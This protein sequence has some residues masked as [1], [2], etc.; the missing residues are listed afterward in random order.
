M[1]F[2][3]RHALYFRVNRGGRDT[4]KAG[5]RVSGNSR[6]RLLARG[7]DVLRG[8]FGRSRWIARV[9]FAAGILASS[10]YSQTKSSEWWYWN[11]TSGMHACVYFVIVGCGCVIP[12]V[13]LVLAGANRSLGSDSSVKGQPAGGA[14]VVTMF[15][16]ILLW[17]TVLYL[18]SPP[19]RRLVLLLLAYQ[20]SML[21]APAAECVRQLLSAHRHHGKNDGLS[22]GALLIALQCIVMYGIN[23]SFLTFTFG[24]GDKLNFDL[25]PY[26]GRLGF[27]A[28]N[29]L[30]QGT[31]VDTAWL[32]RLSSVVMILHKYGP[33][34]LC[35]AFT[36]ALSQLHSHPD[37]VP[38][39]AETVLDPRGQR[40]R[41]VRVPAAPET[42][43]RAREMSLLFADHATGSL[44]L[45][46]LACALGCLAMISFG[47]SDKLLFEQAASTMGVCAS[48]ATL[49]A[50]VRL[51]FEVLVAFPGIAAK[52]PWLMSRVR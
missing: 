6:Q 40:E 38:L 32:S 24:L 20:F 41:R 49:N 9:S 8:I 34:L 44:V 36:A 37:P 25:H 3:I 35:A 45:M 51:C 18:I 2:L 14:D 1:W 48:L 7:R 16:V 42:R 50:V 33:F 26:T 31:R 15:D 29:A 23:Q 13:L 12:V 17:S 47:V 39:H 43:S 46:E 10:I 5:P 27:F 11:A 28:A 19:Y 22:R 52:L 21:L 30:E 4:A